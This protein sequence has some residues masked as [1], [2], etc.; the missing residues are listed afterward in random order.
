M[1][2]KL[3]RKLHL[4]YIVSMKILHILTTISPNEGLI[5]IYVNYLDRNSLDPTDNA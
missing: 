4:N 1:E 3:H 2:F 5:D